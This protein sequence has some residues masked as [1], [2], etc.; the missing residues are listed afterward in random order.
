MDV[1]E[2]KTVRAVYENG[3]MIFTEPVNMEGFWRVEVTFIE[4][5]D[6][7]IPME[8]STHRPERGAMRERLEKVHHQLEGERRTSPY[9]R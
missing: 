2:R 4:Q 1:S 3:E 8:A 5:V 6:T 9:D 7:D